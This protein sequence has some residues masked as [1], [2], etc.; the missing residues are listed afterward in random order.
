MAPDGGNPSRSNMDQ[1]LVGAEPY[2]VEPSVTLQSIHE[3]ATIVSALTS[4]YATKWGPVEAFRELVQ[5]WRDG[6]IHSFKLSEQDFKVTRR[7]NDDEIVYTATSSSPYQDP[8]QSNECLGYIRWSRQ[9]GAGTVDL[10]NREATLKPWHLAMGST[11]KANDRNQTGMHGE[12]LKIA[13]LILMRGPQNH[14]VRCRSGGFEWSFNFTNQQKL[15]TSLVR[16]FPDAISEAH[17]RRDSAP[18]E[19]MANR[20]VQFLIGGSSIQGRDE[21]G[22]PIARAEVPRE[23]FEK[24]TKAAIFLQNIPNEAIVKTMNGDLIIDPR[25]TGNIYLKGFLLKES[26][27]E[28]SAGLTKKML[29]YSYNFVNGTTN[30]ERESMAGSDHGSRT[31][32]TI[33]ESALSIREDHVRLLHELLN[34]EFT[35][36]EG[37]EHLIQEETRK[38]IVSYIK[39]ELKGSWCYMAGQKTAN[40][41]FDQ[42]TQALGRTPL[43]V[44]EP[45]WDILKASGFRTAEE[46]EMKQFDKAKLT[47]CIGR[48]NSFGL[49]LRR[50]IRGG[51]EVCPATTN[52]QVKFHNAGWV[53]LDSRYRHE[54]KELKIHDKW[55][56]MPGAMG[57]LGQLRQSSMSSVLLAAAQWLLRDALSQVPTHLFKSGVQSN[58]FDIT[59]QR[60]P[61][62]RQK[63]AVAQ[64]GQRIDELIQIQRVTSFEKHDCGS[65]N[66]L[67]VKWNKCAAWSTK[68]AWSMKCQVSI[69]LHRKSTCWFAVRNILNGSNVVSENMQCCAY[70]TEIPHK[71]FP[72]ASCFSTKI[73]FEKESFE[74]RVEK[75][76]KEE[77][78]FL[79]MYNQEDLQ[80][81]VVFCE[82][83]VPKADEED[84]GRGQDIRSPFGK[85]VP[86]VRLPPQSVVPSKRAWKE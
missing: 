55:L 73:P 4:D 33:W 78:Y 35:D 77:D 42:I 56:T 17:G 72:A 69:Q 30:R 58:P 65:F 41:R 32:L 3:R 67:A 38:R 13:L 51:L 1:S 79:M 82:S 44:K 16:I 37:A 50:L 62:Q 47:P 7:E 53:G 46:E 15:V 45:Y 48:Y 22:Y 85:P 23:A 54:A 2:P 40:M 81:L 9:D 18:I 66:K 60:T 76:E 5:N 28:K 21:R 14:G 36:L 61:A 63:L 71:T 12:G 6:I 84:Q 10:T 8:T 26:Y 11:T 39:E 70:I 64:S 68:F 49:Q 43:E 57:E 52:T 80:A 20:D 59:S 34:S 27:G 31:I 75:G 19:V 25:C 74:V 86:V 29:R 24:W 83:L